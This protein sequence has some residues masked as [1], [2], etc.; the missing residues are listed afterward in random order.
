MIFY[1]RVPL[2]IL[3]VF[4]DFGMMVTFDADTNHIF[5]EGVLAIIPLIGNVV[6]V[7]ESRAC[8]GC[9]VVLSLFSL[10]VTALSLPSCW[11]ISPEDKVWSSSVALEYV[12]WSKDDCWSKCV[13]GSHRIHQLCRHYEILLR[14]SLRSHPF[15]CCV[16]PRSSAR[17]PSR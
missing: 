2:C 7:G 6:D 9:E 5:P 3:W 16:P 13:P 17:L 4:T 12:P 1:I 14:S 15:L 10:A 8:A 11:I